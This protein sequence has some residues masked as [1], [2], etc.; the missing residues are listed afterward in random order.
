MNL[1]TLDRAIRI[2]LGLAMLAAG[3]SG[4]VGGVWESALKVF[5]WVPL[6][7]GIVGWCPVYAILGFSTRRRKLP[8]VPPG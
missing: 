7:T 3:W 5:G 1:S 2:L 8:H 6:A 4:A